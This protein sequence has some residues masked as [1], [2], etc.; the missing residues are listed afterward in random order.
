MVVY[1]Q[2]INQSGNHR[3]YLKGSIIII[4]IIIIINQSFELLS[5]MVVETEYVWP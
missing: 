5:R 2:S 3:R 4:I 1:A